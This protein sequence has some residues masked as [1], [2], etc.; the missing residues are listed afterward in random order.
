[1]ELKL[2]KSGKKVRYVVEETNGEETY[3]R[4]LNEGEPI[5]EGRD[6]YS[7]KKLALYPGQTVQICSKIA[8]KC[9]TSSFAR[10]MKR[11]STAFKTTRGVDQHHTKK[12]T[13]TVQST[14]V[15][16]AF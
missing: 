14:R 1:V 4:Y 7:D 11:W 2:K 15:R 12:Y 3:E 13:A 6:I 16:N 8:D 5:S 9:L 10:T